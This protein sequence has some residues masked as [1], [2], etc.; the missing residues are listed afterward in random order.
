[1]SK[2]FKIEMKKLW[3]STAMRIMLLVTLVLSILSVAVYVFVDNFA[4]GAMAEMMTV[5][6]YGVL[7]S[8][9]MDTSDSMLFTVLLIAIL[10]GSDFAART[11][12]TQI[13]AGF[14]RVKIIISRYMSTV[15]AFLIFYFATMLFMVG[16]VSI[17]LGFGEKL[18]GEL[19]GDIMLKIF[20]SVFM[21]MVTLSIYMFFCFLVKSTG[22]GIGICLP[23][24]LIGTSILQMLSLAFEA[25]EK[26]INLTPFGQAMFVTAELDGMGY[27][28]FFAV[29]FIW[30]VAMLLL[31][32]ITFKKAELK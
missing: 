17:F 20:M 15:V 4:D 31:T 7:E 16:G 23:F 1:M 26:I 24:M 18:T 5:D 32:H 14:S 2:L 21:G 19:I 8:L 10:I 11:L 22:A 28:K 3:K 6:G 27:F 13:A 25:C 30:M 9:L 12:Q 29:G